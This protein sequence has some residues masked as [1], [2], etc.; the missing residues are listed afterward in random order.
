MF[1][2]QKKNNRPKSILEIL[3][4]REYNDKEGL[5]DFNNYF[6][7][8]IINDFKRPDLINNNFFK[9]CLENYIRYY[10]VDNNLDDFSSDKFIAEKEFIIKNF[11]G[12]LEHLAIARLI[13]SYNVFAREENVY[14]LKTLIKEYR[15]NFTRSSYIEKIKEVEEDLKFVNGI[16]S[17]AVLNSKLINLKGDTI[18]VKD[19]VI[20]DNNKIKV[21]D[22]W[23]S[24]CNPCINEVMIG[25]ESRIELNKNYDIEWLYFSIDKVENKWK[26]KSNELR[27]YGLTKNQYLVLTPETSE[28]IS[29]LNVKTIPRYV[30]IGK[31]GLIATGD[32]VRPSYKE[33]FEKM[34]NNIN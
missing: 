13:A 3:K 31:N 9:T 26:K 18:Q 30:I 19:L 27:E 16:M 32:A 21:I 1:L 34:L 22:F 10:F 6:D 20:K 25:M 29:F 28:L 15:H 33:L 17:D 7:G 4:N 5:I 12:E 2:K 8:I 23:A 14:N 24:W 11:N